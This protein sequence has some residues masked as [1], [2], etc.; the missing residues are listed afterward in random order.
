MVSRPT[1]DLRIAHDGPATFGLVL[2]GAFV[3]MRQFGLDTACR[4]A[5]CDAINNLLVRALRW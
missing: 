5:D 2:Q 4:H 1:S 3:Q